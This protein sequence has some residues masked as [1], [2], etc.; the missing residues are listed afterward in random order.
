MAKNREQME[1]VIVAKIQE[2]YKLYREYNPNG[3]M[4]SM[5]ASRDFICANNQYWKDDKECPIDV[6]LNENGIHSRQH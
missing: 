5:S 4:L 2:L 1:R 6:V 3:D